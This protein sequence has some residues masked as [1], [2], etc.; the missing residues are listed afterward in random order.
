M[1]SIREMPEGKL[2]V[3]F[4]APWGGMCT[5]AG[6]VE[7]FAH[8]ELEHAKQVEAALKKSSKIA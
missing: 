2:D 8:H 7:I 5:V 3:Q 1:Q 6:A 4:K